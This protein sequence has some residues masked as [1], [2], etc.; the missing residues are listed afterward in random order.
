MEFKPTRGKVVIRKDKLKDE[1]EAGVIYQ[2]KENRKFFTGEIL[3]IGLPVLDNNGNPLPYDYEVGDR[4]MV[5]KDVA[6]HE[7][8]GLSIVDPSAIYA[9][10]EKGVDVR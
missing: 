6:Y 5:S 8:A 2:E 10:I 1:T 7:F 9:V 4:V 3:S